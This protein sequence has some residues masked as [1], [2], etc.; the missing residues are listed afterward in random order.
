M[1]M[2][3]YLLDSAKCGKS[4]T[5]KPDS[6]KANNT[7][8]T[9]FGG[10]YSLELS[11]GTKVWLNAASSITFPTSFEGLVRKV[12]ITGEAYFEIAPFANSSFKVNAKGVDISA[13]GTAFNVKAYHNESNVTI[14][15]IEGHLI[16][17]GMPNKGYIINKPTQLRIT[18]GIIKEIENPNIEAATSWKTGYFRFDGNLQ[19]IL[20]QIERWYDVEIN[21]E[22]PEIKV[23]LI[24]QI[25][26][27]MQLEAVLKALT[28]YGNIDFRIDGRKVTIFSK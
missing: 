14:T 22:G 17:K 20:L 24:G 2:G 21:Y 15:L 16:L 9:P 23:S 8:T 7:I 27:S 5:Q 3:I 18:N 10:Q 28:M 25:S 6:A 1:D 26:R 4:S 13:V 11:D 19:S 12:T